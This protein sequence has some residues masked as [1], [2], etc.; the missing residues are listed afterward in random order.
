MKNDKLSLILENIGL[1]E[2]ESKAYLAA[3]SLGPTTV[4]KIAQT[5]EVKRTTVY[6]LLEAL[7]Q[8]GLVRIEMRGMKTRYAAENPEK[9]EAILENKKTAF[10]EALPEFAALYNL[11]G[12]ESL[13]EYHEGLESIKNVY[14]DLI[15]SIHPSESYYVVSNT[16]LWYNQDPKYFEDF[17]YRRAKIGIHARL[18]LEN[19]AIARERLKFQKNHNVT[20]KLMPKQKDVKVNLVVTPKRLAIFQLVPPIFAMVIKNQNIIKHHQDMFDIMWDA[21]PDTGKKTA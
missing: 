4:L 13:I 12:E 5:A 21:I 7:K 1:T 15:E 14:E 9:L 17:Q 2:N 6:T 19:T 16:D 20:I 10:K 8:K 11:R 18:I 3:L